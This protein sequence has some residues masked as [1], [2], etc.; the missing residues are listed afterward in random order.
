MPTIN[1]K[2]IIDEMIK[3]DGHYYD[4]TRAYMIVEYTNAWGGITWGVT[5]ETEPEQSKFKYLTE[6]EF[7]RNPKIIWKQDDIS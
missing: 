7:V 4:D 5:Y 3:G 2:K 1:S 6:T